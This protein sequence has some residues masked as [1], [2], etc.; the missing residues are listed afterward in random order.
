M[1]LEE[2]I[3][4]LQKTIESNNEVIKEARKNG[5]INV[6]QLT[7]DLDNQSI[8]IEIV[9]QALDNSIPKKKIEDE[10]EILKAQCGGN[11]F[12]IQQTLNAEI[13]LLQELLENK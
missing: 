8:A 13:R 12:H 4:V 9:L 5:D 1:K 3:K 10:I 2:A 7:A 11:V 6:M